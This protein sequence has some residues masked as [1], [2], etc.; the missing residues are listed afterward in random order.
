MHDQVKYWIGLQDIKAYNE[1]DLIDDL[2]YQGT[3]DMLSRTKCIVRCVNLNVTAGVNTYTLDQSLLALKDIED[4]SRPRAR[5]DDS[6]SPSFTLIGAD[7]LRLT[8]TPSEY[9]SVQTWAVLKPSKMTDDT[10]SLLEEQFGA[11]PEEWHD[12]VVLYA[13]WKA[14]DYSDDGSAQMGER[15]RMLYEGQNGMGG[16]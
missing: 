9:G 4:E 13:L 8:P 11:I 3:L 7:V 16:R 15:Y 12:A 14:G 6:Y 5:R 1:A 2:P 10:D